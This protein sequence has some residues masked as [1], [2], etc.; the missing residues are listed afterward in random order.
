MKKCLFISILLLLLSGNL[1]AQT[2]ND[3]VTASPDQYLNLYI[4]GNLNYDD[5]IRQQITFVNFMRDRQMASL[6][7]LITTQVTG[8][9]GMEYT[10]FYFGQKEFN[11]KN[12]TLKYV[13][14]K[15][16]TDDET[17]EGLVRI[18]KMGLMPYIARLPSSGNFAIDYNSNPASS[19]LQQAE[20]KD[21]KNW[22]FT[23]SA[24]VNANG[25]KSYQ[26]LYV[27]GGAS[28]GKITDDWKINIRMNGAY[29]YSNYDYD[30]FTYISETQSKS[31]DALIV[32]SLSEHWSAGMAASVYTSTYSNYDFN[33]SLSPAI[34]W[35]LFPYTSSTSRL[36]TIL[37]QLT[38]AYAD[39]TDTTLYDKTSE[40]LFSQSLTSTVSLIEKWGTVSFSLY[41]SNYFHDWS[42]N[43]LYLSGALNLRIVKGLDLNIYGSYGLVH[44]QLSLPKQ[45]A[46]PEE[47]LTRQI[48][49]STNFNYYTSV[50]ISYSFGSIYNNVVNAR[51]NLLE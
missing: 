5:Y 6:H 23:V 7:L 1:H 14:D 50:G 34:E 48:E 35:D 49:L 29:N 41:G 3:T 32:R 45:G 30:G 2:D 15:N 12:D 40:F 19:G 39:Y 11:G 20:T 27:T 13:A 4:D 51:M 31:G 22:V 17:R 26:N 42:K 28:A 44:D 10:L 16:N 18:I 36:F 25:E 21:W 33:G 38:P 47:V 9:G 43:S 24:T 46:T 8:G 37:Y